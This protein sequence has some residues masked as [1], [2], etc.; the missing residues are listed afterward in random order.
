M[1]FVEYAFKLRFMLRFCIL[2]IVGVLGAGFLF[3]ILTYRRLSVVY[4]D[5]VFT[6]YS[7]KKA[8]FPMLFA[9]VESIFLLGIIAVA[10]AVI[11]L[12]FS[13]KIAGPLYHIEKNLEILG[14]GDLTIDTK[15]RSKDQIAELAN[16]ING[17][18]KSLNHRIRGIKEG[19]SEIKTIEG[20]LRILLNRDTT[21]EDLIAVID[22]L[23]N[24]IS[25]L[26]K[27]LGSVNHKV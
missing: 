13:H 20:K 26:K 11:S 18:T 6:I 25:E 24:S 27:F 1:K 17:L 12:F 4:G 21:N 5:A 8:L 15:L 22:G 19:L 9:S 14:S 10:I 16:E 23:R 3:Y 7:V 2:V